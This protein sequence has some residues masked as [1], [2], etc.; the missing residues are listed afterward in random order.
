MW[1][2]AESNLLLSPDVALESFESRYLVLRALW[3]LAT[4]LHFNSY[5]I[6]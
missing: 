4:L 3:A 5:A 6:A 2:Q 1:S